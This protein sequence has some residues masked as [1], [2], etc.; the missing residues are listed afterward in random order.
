M[1]VRNAPS[2]RTWV[3]IILGVALAFSVTVIPGCQLCSWICPVPE[4]PDSVCPEPEIPDEAEEYA[5]AISEFMEA[6]LWMELPW[7]AQELLL[8]RLELVLEMLEQ[9]DY[10]GAVA[11]MFRFDGEPG[12][13]VGAVLDLIEA[14]ALPAVIG[15]EILAIV[16]LPPLPPVGISLP[17]P[18][19]PP[20]CPPLCNPDVD[21][22]VTWTYYPPCKNYEK[23]W[24]GFPD[25]L[26]VGVEDLVRFDA[27]LVGCAGGTFAWEVVAPQGATGYG[28]AASKQ[29]LT[30]LS[31]RPG[32]FTIR[33]TY[34]CPV[35]MQQD[36]DT[37]ILI[38]Q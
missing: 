3:S 25:D 16:P 11:E 35:T 36:T 32:A 17:D 12:S 19:P 5:A 4:C 29:R 20:P 2:T 33:V 27:V 30:F 28:Y 24:T 37:V 13:F 10:D 34:T 1:P 14:E 23:T 9:G 18:P 7:C 26:T 31:E 15:L 8:L 6:I 22:F 38:V 21:I